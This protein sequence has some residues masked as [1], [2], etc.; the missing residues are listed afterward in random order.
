[1]ATL[2]V[3]YDLY[4]PDQNYQSLIDHLKSFGVWW[5]NLDST[6]LVVTNKAPSTVR[7]ELWAEMGD[8]DRL[9]VIDVRTGNW[10]AAGLPGPGVDWLR[11]QVA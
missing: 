10:A 1:M 2:M 3:G 11:E 7:D 5:H 9:L 4:K 8:A 6:W